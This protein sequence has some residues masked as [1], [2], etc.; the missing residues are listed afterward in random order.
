MTQDCDSKRQLLKKVPVAT[1]TY[2][3]RGGD[4]SSWLAEQ[5]YAERTIRLYT[6]TLRRA[7]RHLDGN[8]T[9]LA[10]ATVDDLHEFWQ[11]VPATRSS[12]S[13][14]RYALIAYYQSRGRK[15]GEP[16]NGLPSLPAPYRT[17]RPFSEEDLVTL[18]GAARQLGGAHQVIGELLAGTGCRLGE[19]RHA[20]W[21]QF[22]LA[23]AHP[24]WYIEGKGARRRGVKIRQ[25]PLG[26]AVVTTL[27][28]W[29]VTGHDD[30]L[31]PSEHSRDGFASDTAMRRKVAEI[32]E[33]AN[34]DDAQPHRWRHT[35]ATIALDH[36][37]DLRG[38]QELLGH[39]SLAST[40]IYTKV[41]AGRLQEIVDSLP[42]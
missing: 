35:V 4:F 21:H 24:V 5:G 26:R 20:A 10:R 28:A 11:T 23:S 9:T 41:L 3:M 38:V 17:P 1:D 40:Q 34:L 15:R 37:R 33:S 27:A 25:V 32:A 18:L 31:F 19:L 14:V 42:A 13:G 8:E 29:R 39:E 2:L 36:T 6:Q 22:D 12:R 30:A 16:A 7:A